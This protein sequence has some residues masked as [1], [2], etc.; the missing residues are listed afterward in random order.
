MLFHRSYDDNTKSSLPLE[1]KHSR[2]FDWGHHLSRE[3]NNLPRYMRKAERI[4]EQTLKKKDL[5]LQRAA[6]V[7]LSLIFQILFAVR[8]FKC[9]L[10]YSFITVQ[11]FSS[12]R[13][14]QTWS[15]DAISPIAL[16]VLQLNGRS[17]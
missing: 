2:L 14:E 15:P 1:R 3:G 6:T 10:T 9:L 17:P 4:N 13:W 7:F 12:F 11:K 8:R 5:L 16:F